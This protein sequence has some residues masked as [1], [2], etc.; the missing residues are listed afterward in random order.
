MVQFLG[1]MADQLLKE[2]QVLSGTLL[3]KLESSKL[4]KMPW[5]AKGH[6]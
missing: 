1:T 2:C 5:A 6:K 3:E 4:K